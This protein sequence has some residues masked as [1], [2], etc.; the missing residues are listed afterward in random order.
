MSFTPSRLSK[1]IESCIRKLIFDY[2][3]TY[4]VQKIAVALSGG[5]DSI[6]LLLMLKSILGRGLP[7][8]DLCAIHVSGEFSCGAGVNIQYLAALCSKIRVP[9]S[10]V[11]T[12][13]NKENLNC[14]S[15]SRERRKY[16]FQEA[17]KLF[18][19]HVAFG[20]HQDD[21]NQTLL[22]NLLHKGEFAANLPKVPMV[23]YG[24]TIIRPMLYVKEQDIYEFSKLHGF[25]RITCQCPVGQ[26]SKRMDVKNIID[27]MRDFFPNVSS[28]LALAALKYGSQK[29]LKK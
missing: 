10:I 2:E 20:H 24:V 7:D 17:K 14:Y 3:L 1:K 8:I 4:G 27:Q 25:N 12:S 23:Q 19:S 11:K 22:L 15:C 9:L 6:T 5:K 16:I 21:S 18:A 13:Q 29:A 26:T 28:N